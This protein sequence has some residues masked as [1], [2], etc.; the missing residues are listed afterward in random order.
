[1]HHDKGLLSMG[2][3]SA[4][5]LVRRR[6]WRRLVR[7][8]RLLPFG[9]R[10]LRVP[11]PHR[12]N[13][14]IPRLPQHKQEGPCVSPQPTGSVPPGCLK[15]CEVMPCCHTPRTHLRQWQREPST[16]P[17]RRRARGPPTHLLHLLL[18]A[19]CCPRPV[20]RLV[21]R[22][23]HVQ[24]P[25]QLLERRHPIGSWGLPRLRRRRSLGSS[26]RRRR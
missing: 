24:L 8:R 14:C 10:L 9:G 12:R 21:A 25:L 7:F 16:P 18:A 20:V 3:K 4:S 13:G 1:M 22:L 5:Q 2:S 15:L 17:I 6:L 23:L 11:L 26:H 19:S